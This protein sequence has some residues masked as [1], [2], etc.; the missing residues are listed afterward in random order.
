MLSLPYIHIHSPPLYLSHI[1][2]SSFSPLP[3]FFIIFTPSSTSILLSF[4]SHIFHPIYLLHIYYYYCCCCCFNY[5]YYF[6]LPLLP[7]FAF[8]C[9]YLIIFII[10]LIFYQ[11]MYRGASTFLSFIHALI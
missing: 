2:L 4:Y 9:I 3:L 11:F 7:Y 1:H 5:F 6:Y 10:L 8:I